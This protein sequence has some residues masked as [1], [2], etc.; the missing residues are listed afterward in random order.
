MK[1]VLLKVLCINFDKRGSFACC[2]K[3][4]DVIGAQLKGG[5]KRSV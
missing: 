1:K 3:L 2:N 4:A 5:F